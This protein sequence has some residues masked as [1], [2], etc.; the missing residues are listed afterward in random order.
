MLPSVAL[1]AVTVLAVV[2]ATS[3]GPVTVPFGDT[4]SVLLGHLGLPAGEVETRHVLVIDDI[5]LPRVTTALLAGAGLA[6]AGVVLQ[7]LFRNPLADPGITGVSSGGAVGAVLV[8]ATGATAAGTWVLPAAAFAGA[9]AAVCLLQ[10]AA[11]LRRDHSPATLIL[12]GIA[13]NALL[14]AVVSAVV[15]NAPDTDTVLSLTFWLQ[16]D[17]D[18]ASWN[19]V[20]ILV[21]PV[22]VALAVAVA[23]ARDLNVLLLGEAQARSTGL[24]V[25]RV[26]RFLLVCASLL[27]GVCVCVTGVI[28]FVGLVVPHAVR[29]ALGPDHRLLLPAAALAGGTFLV[30]AD[31]GA[32]MLF[33]PVTLQ[34][35]VVTAFLG[36]P[37]FL[38][39]VLRGRKHV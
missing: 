26:R 11:A 34:T 14:G 16:G 36:A 15:A 31:L 17:L 4:V 20:R 23:F 33:A 12:V 7:A 27:T 3:L 35:G 24:D 32:R 29:L 37:A 10:L 25:V 18:G 21:L 22:L 30:L 9:L 6:V 38:F 2:V 19:G 39:L 1:A 5:R 8:L 13:L 28:G